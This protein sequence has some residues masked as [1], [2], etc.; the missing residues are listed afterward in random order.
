MEKQEQTVYYFY[1]FIFYTIIDCFFLAQINSLNLK[2]TSLIFIWK[3]KVYIN[4][5]N[6]YKQC[7]LQHS[8]WWF[9]CNRHDVLQ[10]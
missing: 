6:N 8:P 1:N 3:K 9:G 10:S 5:E 4:G 7:Y 2:G